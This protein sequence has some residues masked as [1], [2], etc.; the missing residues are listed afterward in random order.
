[1]DPELSAAVASLPPL[2][3]P[4][5]PPT[6]EYLRA[7]SKTLFDVP[8]RAWQVSQLPPESTYVVQDRLIP[9]EGG[10]ITI[11]TVVP[12][13]E[14]PNATFPILFKQHGGGFM[15]GDID[16]WDYYL[17]RLCVD[18]RISVVNVGYRLC[19]EHSY[20]TPVNDCFAALKWTVENTAA[21]KADLSKGLI[22]MG[23]SAG[24]NIA[25]VLAH[26]AR[27]D[28]FFRGRQP[29]G[30]FLCEPF[31]AYPSVYPEA[32]KSEFRSL[33]ENKGYVY[34]PFTASYAGLEQTEA[35]LNAS[36]TDPRC[37]PLLYASHAEL[38]PAYIQAMGIDPLRDD[39]Y[40]YEKVLREA[41]VKTKLDLYPGVGHGFHAQFP[42]ITIATKLWA[43]F[44]KGLEWL[45]QRGE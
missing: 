3:P 26:E 5:G 38:P 16:T 41:G 15:F 10:E 13:D 1:M 20:D 40:V 19:P 22:L 45:L 37:S 21:L 7:I 42:T 25:A 6:L 4:E 23:D 43:D 18:L 29:T 2:P 14:D 8:F 34:Q 27:D 31:V 12:A 39:A 11:R 44:R 24:A 9:V 35:M 32:L 28:P 36:P 33:E 30:Q 17:R